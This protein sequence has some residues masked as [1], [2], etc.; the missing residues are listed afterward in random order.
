[1]VAGGISAVVRTGAVQLRSARPRVLVTDGQFDPAA[2]ELLEQVAD[3]EICCDDWEV[4]FESI[5]DEYQA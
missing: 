5:S 1:M 4:A 3:V 2:R